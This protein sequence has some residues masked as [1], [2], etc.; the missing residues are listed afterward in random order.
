QL[1]GGAL[2]GALVVDPGAR[3]VR[4]AAH[5]DLRAA[6]LVEE[7]VAAGPDGHGAVERPDLPLVVHEAAHQDHVPGGGGDRAEVRHPGG[8][9]AVEA[10]RAAGEEVA[11]VH[12]EGGEHG[13][14]ADV[15]DA[16]GPDEDAVGVDDGDAA[17]GGL[18]LPV[19]RAR[20]APG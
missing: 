4:T 2:D 5:R 1:D 20:V 16:A 3:V 19:D 14:P 18:Q 7:D 8:R 9:V 11:V 10:A 12:A 13:E 6:P 15:D 17:L